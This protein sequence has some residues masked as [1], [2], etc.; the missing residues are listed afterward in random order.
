M[1]I[2]ILIAMD[3]IFCRNEKTLAGVEK[4]HGI[5]VRWQENDATFQNAQQRLCA[6]KKSNELLRLRKMASERT[7][8]L[9][10]KTKYAGYYTDINNQL[11]VIEVVFH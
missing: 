9:E 7:F 1:I 6:K 8:L 3:L 10:L 5:R 4:K 2:L 11:D